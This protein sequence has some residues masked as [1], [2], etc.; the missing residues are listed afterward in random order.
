MRLG[1]QSSV[2]MCDCMRVC[3]CVIA[4]GKVCTELTDGCHVGDQYVW[5]QWD[6]VTSN[7]VK[8]LKSRLSPVCVF[9][10]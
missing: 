4:C 9:V 5:L 2:S 7:D 6:V 3:V 1:T 8:E 10:S